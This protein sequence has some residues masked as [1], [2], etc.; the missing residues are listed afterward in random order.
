MRQRYVGKCVN[1][2]LPNIQLFTQHLKAR[3]NFSNSTAK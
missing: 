3:E 2:K 1:I